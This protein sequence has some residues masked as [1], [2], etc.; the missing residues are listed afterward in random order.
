MVMFWPNDSSLP[1]PMD[2]GK[3]NFG[4]SIYYIIIRN[5]RL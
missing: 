1:R 5:S 3:K 4:E 2:N